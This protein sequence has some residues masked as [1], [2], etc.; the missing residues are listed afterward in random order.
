MSQ[1][2]SQCL[3][4]VCGLGYVPIAPGTVASIA[5]VALW[6][7]LPLS[8][9]GQRLVLYIVTV[10]GIWA[11]GSWA[12]R[13]GKDDPSEVVIDEVAGM[14]LVLV[15]LPKTLPILLIG[16]LLFRLLDI[17]KPPPMKQL[18]RL[19]GGWG[20]MLD[21]VAAGAIARLILIAGLSFLA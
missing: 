17:V 21:D 5:A 4:T 13:V 2:L 10:V 7:W 9:A 20:I 12:R 15:G 16:L 1:R 11:A 6:Y 18:E 8:G 19:P 3:A 14:W